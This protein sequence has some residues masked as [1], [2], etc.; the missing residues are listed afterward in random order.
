MKKYIG[1]LVMFFIISC[2]VWS[3]DMS[4]NKKSWQA[5]NFEEK[6]GTEES[7]RRMDITRNPLLTKVIE[8]GDWDMDTYSFVDILHGLTLAKIRS[9]TILIRNDADTIYYTTN[10]A[11]WADEVH[12]RYINASTIQLRRETG[13]SF[14]STTYNSTSYNRGWIT[15]WYEG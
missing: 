8:I 15:I 4:F 12:I 5:S 13:G 10:V 3:D 2:T 7:T 6:I 14:D 1:L 11:S 9:A